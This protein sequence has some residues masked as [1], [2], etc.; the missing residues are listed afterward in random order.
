[1][2]WPRAFW[3]LLIAFTVYDATFSGLSFHLYSL[4]LERG[5]DTATVVT[6]IAVLDPSQVAGRIAV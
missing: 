3:G 5:L 6:V 4:L 2:A 1:L